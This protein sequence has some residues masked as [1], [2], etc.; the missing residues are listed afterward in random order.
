MAV[1]LYSVEAF[2]KMV[3]EMIQE[4]V[5][6][7][8]LKELDRLRLKE[9]GGT[10][11]TEF[12]QGTTG[13]SSSTGTSGTKPGIKTQSGNGDPANNIMVPGTSMNLNQG[14]AG[15]AKENNFRKKAELVQKISNQIAGMKGV[16]VKE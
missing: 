15:A 2:Q 13:T 9:L 5:K 7:Q 14:L 4:A 11:G 3:R 10:Q 16:V 12:S 8:M 6:E 1:T